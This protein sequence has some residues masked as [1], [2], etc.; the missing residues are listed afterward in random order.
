MVLNEVVNYIKQQINPHL[1]IGYG[2]KYY[3]EKQ[4]MHLE[5]DINK[6]IKATNCKP[7]FDLKTGLSETINY[8]LK[9]K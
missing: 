2:Q 7:V 1:H 9:D 3:S 4:I 5:A 6:L 8:Y